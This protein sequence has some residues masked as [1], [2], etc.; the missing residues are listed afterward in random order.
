VNGTIRGL[1]AEGDMVE[2]AVLKLVVD[3]GGHGTSRLK[4]SK[5]E[6][7]I[8]KGALDRWRSSGDADELWRS[9]PPLTL[10]EPVG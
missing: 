1:F 5:R 2:L 6:V 8:I 7:R 9:G 10:I 3:N 4:D